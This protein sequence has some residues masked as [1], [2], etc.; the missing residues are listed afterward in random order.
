MIKIALDAMGGDH[1]PAVNVE[2]AIEA[3]RE[4]KDIEV[5]LVGSEPGLSAELKGCLKCYPTEKIRIVHT[6]ETVGM[7]E[8][9]SQ[10]IRKKRA[11]SMGKAVELVR[12]KQ[13]DAA[14]SAGNSGA[15]MAFAMLLLGR[16]EGVE[17]PAIAIMMPTYKDPFLLLDAGANAD[18]NPDNMF[19]F[20]LMGDAYSRL[21][22]GIKNPRIS[23][24]SIGEEPAKGNELTKESFKLLKN[25][26][27][28]NFIGN[29]ESKDVFL[30]ETDVLV[31]DGFVGNIF[32]KTSEG[33]ADVLL[34]MLKREIKNTISG[35]FGYLLMHKAIKNFKKKTDYEEY[36]GAPLLGLN[37]AAFICHGR[38]S[39]KAIKNA[40]FKAADYASKN[41]SA[42]ISEEIRELYTARKAPVEN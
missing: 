32:L 6:D 29:I 16:A 35:Q 13:A 37:S 39:A 31:C 27:G 30:G 21:V 25:A 5:I 40:L 20:A 19:Q 3:V 38:S 28:L 24:L 12:E 33:M 7:D 23:L 10:A 8:P 1:A 4:R 18:C 22:L 42:A 2:G 41:V 11:S 14:V 17:R 34:K 26:E 9:P 36:G 15:M